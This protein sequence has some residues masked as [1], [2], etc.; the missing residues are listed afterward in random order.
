MVPLPNRLWPL[1]TRS[2]SRLELIT[3]HIPSRRDIPK[4]HQLPRTDYR[5][6]WTPWKTPFI[7]YLNPSPVTGSQIIQLLKCGAPLRRILPL[8]TQQSLFLHSSQMDTTRARTSRMSGAFTIYFCPVL[9]S[10]VFQYTRLGHIGQAASPRQG[11]R[12]YSPS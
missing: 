4:D 12:Y 1:E 3:N 7:W 10:M 9:L 2:V 8:R 5:Q 11:E 6:T